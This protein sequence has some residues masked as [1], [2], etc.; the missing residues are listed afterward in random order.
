MLLTVPMNFIPQIYLGLCLLTPFLGVIL[1]RYGATLLG[2][3]NSLTWFS[4]ALFVRATGLRPWR[5]LIQL[6]TTR[7]ET[8]HDI[9]HHPVVYTAQSSTAIPTE[10][11]ERIEEALDELRG[12]HEKHEQ[13]QVQA[14]AQAGPASSEMQAVLARIEES[15]EHLEGQSRNTARAGELV[16]L[17]SEEKY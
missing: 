8:L 9:V 10:R 16:R 7:V 11:F 14:A 1:L 13:W 6:L 15:I 4:T 2:A 12:S 17:D 5:H 3:D